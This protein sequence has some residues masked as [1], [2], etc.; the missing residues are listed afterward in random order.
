[1]ATNYQ[2]K[3]AYS[4]SYHEGM[5][6]LERVTVDIYTAMISGENWYNVLTDSEKITKAIKAAKDL[7]NA[8]ENESKSAI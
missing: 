4:N 8:L 3:P 5:S 6:K 7:L 1:M 2:K